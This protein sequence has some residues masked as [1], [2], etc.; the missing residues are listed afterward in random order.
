MY[1]CLMFRGKLFFSGPQD[2]GDHRHYSI[3]NRGFQDKPSCSTVTGREPR[4]S[5]IHIQVVAP[6]IASQF[7][8]VP[9]VFAWNVSVETTG[10]RVKRQY[11]VHIR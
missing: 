9:R 11:T 5:N 3:S 8:H 6:G 4:P 2:R 10:V 1:I 7:G